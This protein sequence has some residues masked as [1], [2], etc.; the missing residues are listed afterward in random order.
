MSEKADRGTSTISIPPGLDRAAMKFAISFLS[1]PPVPADLAA[2]RALFKRGPEHAFGRFFVDFRVR[3][4]PLLT[5]P[6]SRCGG[7]V[8]IAK[9]KS[10]CVA[11]VFFCETVRCIFHLVVE[12]FIRK[13]GVVQINQCMVNLRAIL[14]SP[15]IH[16]DRQI[17]SKFR[18]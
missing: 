10:T 11:Q 13:G 18:Q 5:F 16:T 6:S 9:T 12:L 4:H 15:S 2:E 7:A 8:E 3:P 14:H 17:F 1:S